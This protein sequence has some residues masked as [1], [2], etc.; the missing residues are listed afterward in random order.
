M[1][2]EGRSKESMNFSFNIYTHVQSRHALL[3]VCVLIITFLL[4]NSLSLSLACRHVNFS[5]CYSTPSNISHR[6]VGFGPAA[7]QQ[8][9][10]GEAIE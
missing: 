8:Q 5:D 7:A 10:I 1:G 4:E 2:E 6:R 3:S 9:T